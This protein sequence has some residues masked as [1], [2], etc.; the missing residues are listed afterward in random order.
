MIAYIAPAFE[1]HEDVEFPEDKK[2]LLG[3]C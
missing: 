3:H 1:V 2:Q